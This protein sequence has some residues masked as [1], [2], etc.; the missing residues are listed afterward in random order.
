M[1]REEKLPMPKIEPFYYD[2]T[3]NT[4][5]P[6]VIDGAIPVVIMGGESE[7]GGNSGMRF[8]NGTG[9]PTADNGMEGDIYLNVTNGDLYKKSS[10]WNLLMNLKGAKGDKG[11]QGIQGVKGDKGDKGDTGAKGADGFGTEAQYN[12]IIARLEALEGGA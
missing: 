8:L 1:A 2:E 5:K 6:L 7:T 11:D 4:W 3:S 10:S 9:A 12:D